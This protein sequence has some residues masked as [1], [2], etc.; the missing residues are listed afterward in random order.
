MDFVRLDYSRQVLAN[1]AHVAQLA[2]ISHQQAL[3]GWSVKIDRYWQV[4]LVYSFRLAWTINTTVRA[5][6]TK[7]GV[8]L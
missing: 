4:A 6:F 5:W 2:Y 1:Q 7:I 8:L 3:Q